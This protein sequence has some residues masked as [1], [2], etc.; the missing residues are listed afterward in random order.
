M[1]IVDADNE[2]V[3]GTRAPVSELRLQVPF[4]GP[5]DTL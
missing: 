4:A 2:L 5:Y 3:S 1:S